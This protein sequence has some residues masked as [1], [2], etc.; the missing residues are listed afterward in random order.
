MVEIYPKKMTVSDKYLQGNISR[1][2]LTGKNTI[3]MEDC[4]Y[5]TSVF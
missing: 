4:K 5:K 1:E 2:W 3:D